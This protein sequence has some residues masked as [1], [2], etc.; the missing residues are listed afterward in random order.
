MLLFSSSSAHQKKKKKKKKK[1]KRK[2]RKKK[3]LKKKATPGGHDENFRFFFLGCV[4]CSHDFLLL[5]LASTQQCTKSAHN[6]ALS[7]SF[8]KTL[9]HLPN[10][11]K[12]KFRTLKRENHSK[13]D[14]SFFSPCSVVFLKLCKL[15]TPNKLSNKQRRLTRHDEPKPYPKPYPLRRTD[16]HDNRDTPTFTRKNNNN[17]KRTIKLKINEETARAGYG[18]KIC[19]SHKNKKVEEGSA[20]VNEFELRAGH[21]HFSLNVLPHPEAT[22]SG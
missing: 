21:L 20:P 16:N 19:R 10:T 12:Y 2:K 4:V 6:I 14:S 1:L 17:E 13:R 15:P 11:R 8:P 22:Q 9:S 18:T 5:S 7:S 3:L